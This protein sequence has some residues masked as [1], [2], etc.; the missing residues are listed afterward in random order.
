MNSRWWRIGSLLDLLILDPDSWAYIS[1]SARLAERLPGMALLAS[2]MNR[3]VAERRPSFGWKQFS[4]ICLDLLG[5]R[6][7]GKAKARGQPLYMGVDENC[8]LPKRRSQYDTGGLPPDSLELDQLLDRSGDGS[9]VVLAHQSGTFPDR[10]GFLAEEAGPSDQLLHTLLTRGRQRGR[11]GKLVEKS[12]RDLVDHLVGA[13]GR[14]NCRNQ[15]LPR[16][17]MLELATG[18]RPKAS[19]AV[20]DSRSANLPL[21]EALTKPRQAAPRRLQSSTRRG[22]LPGLR[23]G[24]CFPSSA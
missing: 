23:P 4:K 16:G 1:D 24:H 22:S 5:C 21:P 2:M 7:C 8:R 14:K 9:I 11:I 10:A 19:Q 17:A 18:V 13:L 6:F 20:S 3:T 12:P 15:E